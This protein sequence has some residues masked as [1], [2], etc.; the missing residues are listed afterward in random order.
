MAIGASGDKKKKKKK[1]TIRLYNGEEGT[2]ALSLPSDGRKNPNSSRK[3]TRK[4]AKP[5]N[6]SP[7]ATTA[8]Q[9]KH[10]QSNDENEIKHMN[11]ADLIDE[12]LKPVIQDGFS[13]QAEQTAE[14]KNVSQPQGVT[15]Q[16]SHVNIQSSMTNRQK[17]QG[18]TLFEMAT[19]YLFKRRISGG[20]CLRRL[21]M[22]ILLI[23]VVSFLVL[24]F[25]EMDVTWFTQ[26]F[27]N[28]AGIDVFTERPVQRKAIKNSIAPLR[29]DVN[30]TSNLVA[31]KHSATEPSIVTTPEKIVQVEQSSRDQTKSV[32]LPDT[33][34]VS[35]RNLLYSLNMGRF[36]GLLEKLGVVS[37][38]DLVLLLEDSAD[39]LK[40]IGMTRVQ[41]LKLRRA[42][43]RVLGSQ[44]SIATNVSKLDIS[45]TDVSETQKPELEPAKDLQST[46]LSHVGNSSSSGPD[47]LRSD[48]IN[49]I[50]TE[51]DHPLN[52]LDPNTNSGTEEPRAKINVTVNMGNSET[53]NEEDSEAVQSINQHPRVNSTGQ[54]VER[55]G[56]EF[57]TPGSSH[58]SIA[59]GNGKSDEELGTPSA[60]PADLVSNGGSNKSD[61]ELGATSTKPADLVSNGGS[62]KS[63]E[64]LGATSTK[65][66]DLVS[67]GGSN[68]SDEELDTTSTKPDKL[69]SNRS[70]DVQHS[71]LAT[72]STES[73]KNGSSTDHPVLVGTSSTESTG[74]KGSSKADAGHPVLATPSTENMG[75]KGSS[76]ADADHPVLGAPSTGNMESKGSSEADA[77]HP[78][79]GTPSSEN[80][81]SKRSSKVDVEQPFLDTQS[82]VFDIGNS[83]TGVQHPVLDTQ[84]E[85]PKSTL[86]ESV[87]SS[88]ISSPHPVLGERTHSENTRGHNRGISNQGGGSQSL[89]DSSQGLGKGDGT[90]LKANTRRPDNRVGGPNKTGD[91][92][93]VSETMN[94]PVLEGEGASALKHSVSG[95]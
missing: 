88:E 51:N 89:A 46:T 90:S 17:K 68:K 31:R 12:L 40:E 76:K 57:N 36:I 10:L 45:E 84:S 16:R 1:F 13:T 87:G 44:N 39:D 64:E 41:I 69:V 48:K 50:D 92:S 61:E 11:H 33:M 26:A 65:P 28:D 30:K 56:D 23:F 19:G 71:I 52:I 7:Q 72:A 21:L 49:T 80:M 73:Y 67:N 24:Y 63:D 82:T 42:L 25:F 4:I 55:V 38:D 2:S 62:N 91:D 75:P 37:N 9:V 58:G 79:L 5:T 22:F 66:A 15:A 78:V 74:L 85:E 6:E 70:V 77:D 93:A 53:F 83:K 81:G 14:T 20:G 32:A 27:G 95:R 34:D 59:N 47:S 8:E 43:K 60:K 54:E 29:L 35:L 86:V 94:D 18:E 3:K